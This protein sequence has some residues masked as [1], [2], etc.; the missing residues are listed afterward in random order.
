MA[1]TTNTLRIWSHVRQ[2]APLSKNAAGDAWFALNLAP[3]LVTDPAGTQAVTAALARKYLLPW[4]W[5]W[6]SLRL[7]LIRSGSVLKVIDV[8][9]TQILVETPIPELTGNA[10]DPD[11]GV[12]NHEFDATAHTTDG[13]AFQSTSFV[14][15][16]APSNQPVSMSE[17]S[18]RDW[19]TYLLH[20]S[21]YAG[22]IPLRAGLAAWFHV[23]YNQMLSVDEIVVAPVFA[24]APFA[25]RY[26]PPD[27]AGAACL[28][29]ATSVAP[30][31]LV[32]LKP[33]L[34]QPP[35]ATDKVW[36]TRWTYGAP[37]AGDLSLEWIQPWTPLR[38][39]GTPNWK[40]DT[41]GFIAEETLWVTPPLPADGAWAQGFDGHE[42]LEQ[43]LS[44]LF[45]LPLR[46]LEWA[47]QALLNATP[48]GIDANFGTALIATMRDVMR[49]TGDPSGKQV[50][51][52]PDSGTVAEDIARVLA[53]VDTNM[54]QQIVARVQTFCEQYDQ[55]SVWI[56]R[57]KAAMSPSGIL[58]RQPNGW[59]NPPAAGSDLE[60]FKDWLKLIHR[61]RAFL[62]DPANLRAFIKQ[63]WDNALR[64][65][66]FYPN[67]LSKGA[68]VDG[69]MKYTD[70]TTV[71]RLGFLGAAWRGQTA[72]DWYSPAKLAQS[73]T[74]ALITV[75]RDRLAL[76]PPSGWG[77]QSLLPLTG[78]NVTKAQQTPIEAYLTKFIAQW[79]KSATGPT[80]E[81]S[82][83]PAD[84]ARGNHGINIQFSSYAIAAATD[85]QAQWEQQFL[86]GFRGVG[87]MLRPSG[88]TP[89]AHWSVLHL[90]QYSVRDE[91]KPAVFNPDRLSLAPAQIVYRNGLRQVSGT[92]RNHPLAARSPAAELS[93]RRSFQGEGRN[94]D[95]Y[96]DQTTGLFELW[97][98]YGRPGS[99]YRI[100][101]LICGVSYDTASFAVGMGGEHPVE[102]SDTNKPWRVNADPSLWNPPASAIVTT[103]P[104]LRTVPV[105]VVR[106]EGEKRRQPG[107]GI[108]GMSG[109]AMP[110]GVFPMVRSLTKIKDQ[111]DPV[112]L[113]CDTSKDGWNPGAV[114]SATFFMRPPATDLATFDSWPIA[115]APPVPDRVALYSF[116]AQ[117]TDTPNT[118]G[119]GSAAP[120]LTLDD[121]GVTGFAVTLS[122]VYP[123]NI[124]SSQ[125]RFDVR[126]ALPDP[127]DK[128]KLLHQYQSP[129]V[130]VDIK[131]G[132]ELVVVPLFPTDPYVVTICVPA[133]T[134]YQVDI[135]PVTAPN[136][137]QLALRPNVERRTFYVEVAVPLNVPD[138]N[139]AADALNNALSTTLTFPGKP[140][141]PDDQLTVTLDLGALGALAPQIHRVELMVQR[142][143]WQ[144]RPLARTDAA[145]G[146][147]VY[148]FP[149]DQLAT[150]PSA[151]V[152]LE[153]LD[154]IYFGERDS[155][156]HLIVG[157]SVDSLV[158]GGATA[159]PQIYSYDLSSSLQALYYR[160]AVRVFSRYEGLLTRNASVESRVRGVAPGAPPAAERWRRVLPLCR[161]TKQAPKPAI[162]LII[163]LTRT[164]TGE[165][166]PGLLAVLDDT[167]YDWGG[168]A[169]KLQISVETV[170][171]PDASKQILTQAGPDPV[172]SNRIY[173]AGGAPLPEID[174]NVTPIGPIGFTS[175]T[176][177]VAPLFTKTSFVIPAPQ[178]ASDGTVDFSWWILQLKFRRA[179][180]PNGAV[181]SNRGF[182]PLLPPVGNLPAGTSID[183]A[184]TLPMQVQLLPSAN[185]WD[186]T[187][188]GAT[189]SVRVDAASLHADF[190]PGNITVRDSIEHSLTVNPYP[191]DGG[192]RNRFEV[193]V[194]LTVEL[195]DAFG[196]G[197]QEAFVNL[198]PFSLLAGSATP[199][200]KSQPNTLRLVEVQCMKDYSQ[201]CTDW[202]QLASDLF[203]VGVPDAAAPHGTP[204]TS[205]DPAMARARIV[206]VSPPIKGA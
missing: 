48:S 34:D 85:A 110:S 204:L 120:D 173:G 18:E 168:L 13:A 197:G 115:P 198:V 72:A 184:W 77:Y 29:L 67:W 171:A 135:A 97:N 157:A 54:Q 60:L 150:A 144:G 117:S 78:N 94:H 152:L 174:A 132:P 172:V 109:P 134:V 64:G 90:G 5:A 69:Y 70:I 143:R 68:D 106:M 63:D 156:D 107:E 121:P 105:G 123:K 101:R 194:L 125:K 141:K 186:V 191:A 1:D 179:L 128:L 82:A 46:L 113:L 36:V 153:P 42:Q 79:A 129:S 91:G 146:D 57:L 140:G 21:T 118:Q 74:D 116:L 148:D 27:P 158:P 56:A 16:N 93:Q 59:E 61:A 176:N 92:Y 51:S 193:W 20:A 39:P 183:S 127:A 4:T 181:A 96:I 35:T 112:F 175:D 32:R 202:T 98:P 164:G 25:S 88:Q 73:M 114:N 205:I 11:S 185:L 137:S 188:A 142:W 15:A 145:T 49:T 119:T 149:Y 22:D 76:Q 71:L 169:E 104:Y 14:E 126:R 87:M 7:A 9:A 24:N 89:A 33:T 130:R 190:T 19:K 160:F 40:W 86:A 102:I 165:S 147:T 196:H 3:V 200:G 166:T 133:G 44:G 81:N 131:V 23:P 8:P 203:P 159:T 195:E 55:Y 187:W 192:G 62:F 26:A 47:D 138:L 28:D 103:K 6:T 163:P 111:Q 139:A 12:F 136:Y 52:R 53:P 41:D 95:A 83:G 37:T 17:D 182:L 43:R 154:G 58:D 65:T 99:P 151:D 100:P 155:N 189:N 170:T 201:V 162:R 124:A 38:T 206:R 50:V 75:Y 66:P 199:P 2:I 45:D 30:C 161:R 84:Y 122:Q 10:A 80:P 31:A 108:S 180:N 177:T 178:G 167:W